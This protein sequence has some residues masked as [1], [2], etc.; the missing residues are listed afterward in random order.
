MG[1]IKPFIQYLKEQDEQTDK[2]GKPLKGY[3]AGQIIERI[4]QLMQIL[5]DSIRFGV[6]TDTLGRTTTYRDANGAIQKIKDHD[7]YYGSKDEDVRFYCWSISYK[8]S[9]EA[10]QELKEKIDRDGG[11]GEEKLN[12]NLKKLLNYFTKNK[13]DAD[14]IQS[15]TISMDS[16]SIR[17]ELHRKEEESSPKKP[18]VEKEKTDGIEKEEKPKVDN[19]DLESTE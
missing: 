8:G 17:K 18:K 3:K 10:T 16:K 5:P 13:E 6:P 9:W 14:S 1:K 19:S 2:T 15:I 11:F 12:M 7:H 4:E